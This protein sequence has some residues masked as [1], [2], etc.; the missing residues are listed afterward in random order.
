MNRAGLCEF[1]RPECFICSRE[2]VKASGSP[3]LFFIFFCCKEEAKKRSEKESEILVCSAQS[4]GLPSGSCSVLTT[5]G[6]VCTVFSHQFWCLIYSD[7]INRLICNECWFYSDS[8]FVISFV[9]PLL[10]AWQVQTKL[11]YLQSQFVFLKQVVLSFPHVRKTDI[12]QFGLNF[13][14]LT[15]DTFCRLGK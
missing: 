15:F 5:F 7:C 11:S 1:H 2:C 14:S 13:L 9:M 8:F 3:L 6:N 10:R 12:V 4:L